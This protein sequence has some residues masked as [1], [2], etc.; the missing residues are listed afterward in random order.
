MH[1][2]NF[3]YAAQPEV[4]GLYIVDLSIHHQLSS[5][6]TCTPSESEEHLTSVGQSSGEGFERQ[7]QFTSNYVGL[8]IKRHS[9]ADNQNRLGDPTA[10]EQQRSDLSY[11]VVNNEPFAT[12]HFKYRSLGQYTHV[13]IIELCKINHP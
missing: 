8:K 7:C 6:G 3:R 4:G 11:Q 10:C 2:E 12:V 13:N 5:V 1:I 9:I